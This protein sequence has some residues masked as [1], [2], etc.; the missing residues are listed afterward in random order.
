MRELFARERQFG[1]ACPG[2]VEV[3]AHH[4]MVTCGGEPG[5]WMGDW[6]LDIKNCYGSLYWSAIDAAVEVHLPGALPWT[7][8]LHGR[9]TRV[10]L[11]GGRAH[12]T[13]RGA[14]QGDPL[15]GAY[16]AAALVE[17]CRR[18]RDSRENEEEDGR[19]EVDWEGDDGYDWGDVEADARESTPNCRT[20]D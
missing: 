16:A 12:E 2:G 19:G 7:R 6:D 20:S 10:V 5:S 18:A 4:R 13:Q 8:W 15:G 17:A 1:V 14:E 3:L 11:P 9:S